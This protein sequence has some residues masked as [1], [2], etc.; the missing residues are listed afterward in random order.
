MFPFT[1]PTKMHRP[2]DAISYTVR[3]IQHLN[4]SEGRSMCDFLIEPTV[5]RRY[6][7]FRFEAYQ[8]IFKIGY[9]DTIDY[10]KANPEILK[11]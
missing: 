6:H 5:V 10:I 2:I 11:I 4:S 3:G 1:S 9:K 7:E 8:K